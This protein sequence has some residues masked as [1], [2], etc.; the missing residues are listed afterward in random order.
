MSTN[1]MARGIREGGWL[2]IVIDR[3]R[4]ADE[5]QADEHLERGNEARDGVNDAAK[6]ANETA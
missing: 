3:G 2:G 6:D 1:N 4:P 5:P